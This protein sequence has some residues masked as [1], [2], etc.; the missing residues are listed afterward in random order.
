MDTIAN[1]FYETSYNV[2]TL[3]VHRSFD[4]YDVFIKTLHQENKHIDDCIGRMLWPGEI[5]LGEFLQKY[6][7]NGL[8]VIEVGSG[9]GYA[10]FCCKGA[11]SIR[12]TDYL[13]DILELEKENIALNP[14]I[15]NVTTM[16]LDW[17]EQ[18]D[19]VD[20]ADLIFGSE[21]LYDPEL[22]EPLI[23]TISTLLKPK[24]QCIFINNI[25]RFLNCENLFFSMISK[26]HLNVDMKKLNDDN[27]LDSYYHITITHS[28]SSLDVCSD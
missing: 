5:L 17:F 3:S 8:D 4:S 26:Y 12:M 15:P 22:V 25:A 11:K 20:K 9:V 1:L 10:S 21:I 6:D 2:Q 24:S 18:N 16:K 13:E 28:N 27:I 19:G 23:K 7:V 14:H